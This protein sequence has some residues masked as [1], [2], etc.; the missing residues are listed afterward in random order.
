MG[1]ERLPE[2]IV[3]AIAFRKIRRSVA[4]TTEN[5]RRNEPLCAS[6]VASGEEVRAGGELQDFLVL[7]IPHVRP[8]DERHTRNLPVQG[9]EALTEL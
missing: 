9:F 4:G 1:S 7:E 8:P 5:A 2:V 6:G 3:P